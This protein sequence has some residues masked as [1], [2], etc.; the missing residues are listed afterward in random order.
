MRIYPGAQNAENGSVP[1][2]AEGKTYRVVGRI[3]MDQMVVDLGEPGL[4]DPA[5]GYLG[6]PA[7]LFGAGE[8][9]PVEEWAEAAQTINYE[10]VTRIS[11]RVERLYVG[12]SWVEAELNELWGTGEEQ[13]G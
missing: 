5:L 11:P 9:P 1:N 3:A 10:I 13:E 4:S 12:G 7:I 6:A 8:N 2:N